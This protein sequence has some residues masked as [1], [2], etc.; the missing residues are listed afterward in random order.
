MLLLTIIFLILESIGKIIEDT[1]E[2]LIEKTNPE[3]LQW[4]HHLKA[5]MIFLRKS[6]WPLRE[7][8]NGLIRE[9]TPVYIRCHFDLYTRCL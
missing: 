8:I 3:T 9:E 5:N 4:I 2:N 1:E 7:L 6:I